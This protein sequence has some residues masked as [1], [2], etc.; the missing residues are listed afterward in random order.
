MEE[1]IGMVE[2]MDLIP[3][4]ILLMVLILVSIIVKN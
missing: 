1:I 3:L 4:E 2:E